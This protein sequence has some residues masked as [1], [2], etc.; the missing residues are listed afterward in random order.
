VVLPSGGLDS[1]TALAIAAREG[2]ATYALSFRY[3]R[4]QRIELEAATLGADK[5]V[6]ADTD[7]RV[8]GG[9]ALRQRLTIHTPLIQPTKA[10]ETIIVDPCTA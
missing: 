9:S 6:V 7:L 2:F 10:A 4:R 1:A 5:H 8:L 3:G